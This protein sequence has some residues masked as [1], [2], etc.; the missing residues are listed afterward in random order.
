MRVLTKRTSETFVIDKPGRVVV[1]KT[2]PDQVKLGFLDAG[3]G[4]EQSRRETSP[5]SDRR[6]GRVVK[7]IAPYGEEIEIDA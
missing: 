7:V 4:V 2:A 3:E 1:L 5:D 6:T